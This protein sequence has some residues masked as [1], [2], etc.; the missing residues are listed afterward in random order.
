MIL[1][2]KQWQQFCDRFQ[3]SYVKGEVFKNER[4]VATLQNLQT[5]DIEDVPIGVKF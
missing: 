2:K 5:G 4:I 1:R 3:S